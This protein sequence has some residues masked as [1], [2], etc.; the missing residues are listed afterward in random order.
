MSVITSDL[1]GIPDSRF[2]ILTQSRCISHKI[3]ILS[4]QIVFAYIQFMTKATFCG[5]VSI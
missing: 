3:T 1:L 5:K 2:L 4:K